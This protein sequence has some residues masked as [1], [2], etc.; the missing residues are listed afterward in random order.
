MRLDP[1][2]LQVIACPVCHSA[3]EPD[4]A[5]GELLC[6]GCPRAYPVRDDI[7]VLLADQARTRPTE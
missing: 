5:A 7:P 3:L 2:L 4:D 6:T 1:T